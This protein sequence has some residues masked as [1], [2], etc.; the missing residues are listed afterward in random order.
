MILVSAKKKNYLNGALEMTFKSFDIDC[1]INYNDIYS[2]HKIKNIDCIICVSDEEYANS[3][4]LITT[5]KDVAIDNNT[6]IFIMGEKD[7][8]AY[9]LKL[10]PAHL[11]EGVYDR[12]F[13][14][15]EA[16]LGIKDYIST[17]NVVRD[18]VLIVDDD[19]VMAMSLKM[20]LE[21]T[22]KYNVKYVSNA[23]DALRE[24]FENKPDVVLLDYQMPICNGE[25]LLGMIRT[26]K[27]L[28]DLPVIICS[29]DSSS[30]VIKS[31]MKYRP[32]GYLLKPVD[33]VELMS[34]IDTALSKRR[35]AEKREI[36]ADKITKQTTI[37]DLLKNLY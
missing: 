25:T 27:D 15:M 32:D 30:N 17:K 3:P 34:T 31:L 19:S 13:N 12:P 24:C 2:L 26:S 11:I 9:L 22:R 35:Q 4:Q 6:H 8:N 7:H 21:Q 18:S 10:F 16:C 23:V 5:I 37:S 28:K 20:N 14:V 29:G 36:E 33:T 1:K